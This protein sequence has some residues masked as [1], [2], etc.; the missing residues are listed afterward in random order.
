MNCFIAILLFALI[1]ECVL[2]SLTRSHRTRFVDLH[3]LFQ[4]NILSCCACVCVG[5]PHIPTDS[6]TV[7]MF[8]G[9]HIN[10]MQLAD[11]T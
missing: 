3:K 10:I 1:E 11:I 2:I 4:T 9:M 6:S 8:I 5:F 7:A